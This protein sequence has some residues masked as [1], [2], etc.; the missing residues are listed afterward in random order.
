MRHQWEWSG[1]APFSGDPPVL[2]RVEELGKKPVWKL[3]QKTRD[4]SGGVVTEVNDIVSLTSFVEPLMLLTCSDGWIDIR[5]SWSAKV[6]ACLCRSNTTGS[7]LTYH[8]EC[9]SPIWM[10]G[11]WRHSYDD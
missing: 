8:P 5:V 3:T 11:R 1:L 9:G 10:P 6:E 4:P 7:R 2:A